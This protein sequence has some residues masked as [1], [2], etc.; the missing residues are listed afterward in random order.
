MLFLHNIVPK[1]GLRWKY[2]ANHGIIHRDRRNEVVFTTL[3]ALV[4]D[5]LPGIRLNSRLA[6]D[7][8]ERHLVEVVDAATRFV[9]ETPA[10]MDPMDPMAG[11]GLT[12]VHNEDF[13]LLEEEVSF[14]ERAREAT[15]PGQELT[16]HVFQAFHLFL[17]IIEARK[18]F[19]EFAAENE[20]TDMVRHV[21]FGNWVRLTPGRTCC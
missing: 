16:N 7:Q 4:D 2:Y 9:S 5:V 21:R 13:N 18:H 11:L 19:L 3:H 14:L 8:V 10:M 12:G 1:N 20:S 15:R 17:A 6:K